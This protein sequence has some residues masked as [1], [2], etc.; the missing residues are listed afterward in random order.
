LLAVKLGML[1]LQERRVLVAN[2][3]EEPRG[4]RSALP[5]SVGDVEST[6]RPS[7]KY[8]YDGGRFARI[9]VDGSER[10]GAT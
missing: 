5:K 2:R 4:A 6:R 1:V 9:R 7:P 3:R 8:L 10:N